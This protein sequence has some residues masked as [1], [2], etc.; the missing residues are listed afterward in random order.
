MPSFDGDNP[1]CGRPSKIAASNRARLIGPPDENTSFTVSRTVSINYDQFI[2]PTGVP[3]SSEAEVREYVQRAS[4]R[5]E[6]LCNPILVTSYM[7]VYDGKLRLAAARRLNYPL[8]YVVDET[9]SVGHIVAECGDSPGWGLD[10]YCVYYAEQGRPEYVR[11]L[12]FATTYDI[13][14]GSA[15]SLL[16]GGMHTCTEEAAMEF[17]L[18]YFKVT[19]EAHALGVVT[20]R[21]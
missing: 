6:L 16:Q 9:L 17:E 5:E 1:R 10:Q 2:I 20:R 19:H 8:A 12:I 15:A 21:W 7:E 11:V 14:I 13:S 4:I 3:E 18:G